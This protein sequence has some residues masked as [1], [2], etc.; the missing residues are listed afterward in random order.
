MDIRFSQLPGAGVPGPADLARANP[1]AEHRDLVQ[2]V[3]T[4]NAAE[5]LGQDNELSFLMDRETQRP[6]LRLVNRKTN[7]VVRQVPPEH[8]LRLARELR[9]R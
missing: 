5:M 3:R 6:I 7:E 4:V 8:V 1:V 2:A 9:Q